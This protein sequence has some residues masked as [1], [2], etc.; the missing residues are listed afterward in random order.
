MTEL[1]WQH[2]V[3]KIFIRP[4]FFIVAKKF[5]ADFTVISACNSVDVVWEVHGLNSKAF[6]IFNIEKHMAIICG[7]FYGGEMKKGI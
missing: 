2:F 6:V 7:T 1:A 5:K 4:E 3:T